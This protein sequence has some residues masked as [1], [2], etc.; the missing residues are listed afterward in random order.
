MPSGGLEYLRQ[1]RVGAPSCPIIVVT[2][3]GDNATRKEV[4]ECGIDAFLVKP[5]R[6]ANLQATIL[7]CLDGNRTTP[8]TSDPS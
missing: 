8:P 3:L 1:L 6:I 5:V 7:Q 4:L 2:D